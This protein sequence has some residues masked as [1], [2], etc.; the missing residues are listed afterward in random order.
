MGSLGFGI[1]DQTFL[2]SSLPP[3]I[4]APIHPPNTVMLV[5]SLLLQLVTHRVQF[6]GLGEGLLKCNAVFIPAVGDKKA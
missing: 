1:L 2:P 6:T 5:F 3:Y 4:H